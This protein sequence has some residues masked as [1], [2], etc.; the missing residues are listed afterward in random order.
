[1]WPQIVSQMMDIHKDFTTNVWDVE[2]VKLQKMIQDLV[3]SK[4]YRKHE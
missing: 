2:F 4:F 3:K 1:M